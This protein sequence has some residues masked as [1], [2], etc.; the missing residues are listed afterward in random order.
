MS[1]GAQDYG[2]RERRAYKRTTAAGTVTVKAYYSRSSPHGS[3]PREPKDFFSTSKY[4]TA[5]D[6]TGTLVDAGYGGI[7]IIT[8]LALDCNCLIEVDNS[9]VRMA[10]VR[11]VQKSGHTYHAGLMYL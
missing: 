1:S 6:G 7:Q 8:G 4:Y 2:E 3:R 10:L 9:G 5:V 11:W